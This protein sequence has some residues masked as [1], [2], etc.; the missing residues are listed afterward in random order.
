M[1]QQVCSLLATIKYYEYE[2]CGTLISRDKQEHS[3]SADLLGQGSPLPHIALIPDLK[4][5]H[6]D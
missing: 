4:S 2:Q 3:E 1:F 6:G 5:H